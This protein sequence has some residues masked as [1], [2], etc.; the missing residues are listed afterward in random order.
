MTKYEISEKNTMRMQQI[1]LEMVKCFDL[2]CKKNNLKYFLC[3]GCCIGAIRHKGF[4]PWD[5]DVD[6]FMMREDFEKLKYLWKDTEDYEIQYNRLDK[7]AYS[8]ILTIHDKNTTYIKTGFH[9]RDVSQGVAMDIFPLD[10]AP[11]GIKRKI[12]MFWAIIFSIY[13]VSRAPL[14]HGNLIKTIGNILLG[15]VP[16]MR[17]RYKIAKFAEKQ[18][19]KYKE[20]NCNYITELC[21]GLHYMKN[22]YDKD[23]FDNAVYVEFEDTQLPI[24]EGYNRYLT[25][26]F[27]DY[28]VL[29]PLEKREN[30]HAYE[31]IDLDSP[32]KVYK[33]NKYC[34]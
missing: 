25:K 11:Q 4:I 3:G 21:A 28:M 24:P 27:G 26:A 18:M 5:D 30:H 29:P 33:G 7:P 17:A 2:F 16:S 34:K 9:D 12:Q 31:F 19:S 8:T 10:Y 13:S 23:I 15:V 1:G 6:I 14:N 32:Y 22:D 20:K